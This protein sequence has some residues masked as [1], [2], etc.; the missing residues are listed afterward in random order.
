MLILTQLVL[1]NLVALSRMLGFPHWF[2]LLEQVLMSVI[3]ERQG[4][5]IDSPTR[6]RM[7]K[8]FIIKE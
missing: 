2:S 8:L 6:S 1:S 4:L 5:M 3:R 7:D